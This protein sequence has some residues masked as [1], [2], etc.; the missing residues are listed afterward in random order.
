MAVCLALL[1]LFPS[2]WAWF[3]IRFGLGL[4]EELVFITGDI[5]INQLAEER[6]RG[7]LIGIYGAFLH[8]GFAVGP[9]TI[10]AL[11]TG[12]WTALYL[13]I[14][15]VLLGL[16]PLAA[17]RGAA[18]ATEGK[19]RARLRHYLRVATTLMVAGLM[20]GLIASATESLL[21]VYALGKG[22]DEESAA[23]LLT[24]FVCGS[25][26]GQL[27][28]G[29]LADHVEHRRLLFAGSLITLLALATL[30]L[31]IRQAPLMWLVMLAMGASLGSFYV[32]AMTMMGRRYRGADLI[33][34][35]TSFVF[36]WGVGA[37][38]GPGLSGS[39]MTAFGPDGMPALGVLLC[40]A[41][42]IVCLRP[43]QAR[44]QPIRDGDSGRA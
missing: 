4:C 23:L 33:G 18:P 12:D 41:F 29:W 25:V 21:P 38:L 11:G 5:W 27:P 6:T 36:I 44:E 3:P 15:V 17:A 7:R 35:N 37:T 40:A 43:E 32:V 28:V 1:P 20:F 10:I 13:G 26:L 19:P 39:A 24:L 16:V 31:V 30:P 34:V 9:L 42:L 8:G 22:L 2:V 14:A